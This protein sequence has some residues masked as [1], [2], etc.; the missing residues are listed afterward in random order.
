M[1]WFRAE[2]HR[3]AFGNIVLFSGCS[4]FALRR[5]RRLAVERHVAS[6]T[7]I[8]V[9]GDAAAEFYVL[10]EGLAHAY[11]GPT[12]VGTVAPGT[13]FGEIA[14]LDG[15][16]RT[17]TVRAAL[18]SRVL[19]FPADALP[20]LLRQPSVS[21]KFL[22]VLAERLRGADRLANGSRE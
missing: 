7:D 22:R 19:A 2:P 5:L 9:Q 4:R 8:V 18:P 16:V 20:R 21:E 10:M 3:E 17:A 6:G 14:V 13:V 11:V 12:R 15:S 1:A